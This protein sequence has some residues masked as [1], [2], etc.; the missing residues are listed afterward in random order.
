MTV[1][2]TGGSAPVAHDRAVRGAVPSPDSSGEVPVI[3]GMNRD[4]VLGWKESVAADPEKADRWPTV[5]AEW[6]GGSRS[7]ITYQ[8]MTTHIGGDGELNPMQFVL[9]ALAACDVDLIAMHASMIDLEIRNL[10][11]EVSGH[12]NV[13]SYAGVDGTPGSGYDQ[14]S[15]KVVLD[16]PDATPD[17]IAYLT[18]RCERSSPV[19]D[20]LARQVV[21]TLE[22]TAE[23]T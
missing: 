16:A 17:Q 7:Q 21:M 10:H 19:G 3:N 8:G 11:V 6:L 13:Q 14:V 20:T 4:A 18:E 22:F 23:G 12:F 9:A 1:P 15:Y 2:G 5:I